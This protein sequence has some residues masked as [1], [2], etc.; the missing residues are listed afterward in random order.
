MLHNVS[1][2][3][4]YAINSVY[5][6]LPIEFAFYLVLPIIAVRLARLDAAGASPW[7][8]L[9]LLYAAALGVSI[10]YRYAA[11]PLGGTNIAWISKQLPGAIDQVWPGPLLGAPWAWRRKAAGAQARR[12]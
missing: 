12:G 5:W 4:S 6:T 11:H 8:T 1:E 3:A 7:K 2:T 9:V 10:A